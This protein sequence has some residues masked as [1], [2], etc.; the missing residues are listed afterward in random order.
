MLNDNKQC[1]NDIN[2]I[3][4]HYAFANN[5]IRKKSLQMEKKSPNLKFP[6]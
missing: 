4:K 6:S 3:E 5:K 2:K 1:N